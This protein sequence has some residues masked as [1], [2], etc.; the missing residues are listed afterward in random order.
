MIRLRAMF[1]MHPLELMMFGFIQSGLFYLLILL[2]SGGPSRLPLW[3]SVLLAAGL[4]SILLVPRSGG[5]PSVA[6][7]D[8]LAADS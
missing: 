7:K 1:E 8:D 3:L 5:R 6:S 2:H 4:A